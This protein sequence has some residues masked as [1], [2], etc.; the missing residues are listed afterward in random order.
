MDALFRTP[1]V[2]IR[3]AFLCGIAA[4]LK[5]RHHPLHHILAVDAV[6]TDGAGGAA[7]GPADHVE[8]LGDAS[9]VIL[10]DALLDG[11]P[12]KDTHLIADAGNQK[13]AV[14]LIGLTSAGGLAID[15]LVALEPDTGDSV[16]SENLNRAREKI[17]MD[18]APLDAGA[19]MLETARS[20][21]V[22][23]TFSSFLSSEVKPSGSTDLSV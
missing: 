17:E 22:L 15:D 20:R 14:D 2:K 3:R 7:L 23:T 4:A 21:L 19:D 10:D 16:I 13:L 12:F 11:E 6:G 9:L 5:I 18:G 8:P 1:G